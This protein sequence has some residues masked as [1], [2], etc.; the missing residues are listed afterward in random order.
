MKLK[1]TEDKGV[2]GMA[3]LGDI[4]LVATHATQIDVYKMTETGNA[5][6]GGIPN[7]KLPNISDLAACRLTKR[8]Y[9]S[10]FDKFGVWM[11]TNPVSVAENNCSGPVAF[12][13]FAKVNKAQGL[14]VSA[15]GRVVVVTGMPYSIFVFLLDGKLDKHVDLTGT[16]IEDPYQAVLDLDYNFIVCS[17]L[18]TNQRH[19]VS[20]ISYSGKV[21]VRR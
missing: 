16:G 18:H 3:C 2:F 7:L 6:L 10:D 20:R 17:G 19:S 4:L 12:E 14:S 13:R 11:I 5:K 1:T 21:Q 15:E 8:L 9:I